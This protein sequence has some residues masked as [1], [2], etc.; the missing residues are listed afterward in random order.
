MWPFNRKKKVSGVPKNQNP[1][2]VPSRRTNYGG[3]LGTVSSP[4]IHSEAR[5]DDAT[6]NLIT[7]M[8]IG[9]A[10]SNNDD[11]SHHSHHSNS[12][13]SDSGSWGGGHS[14]G[15]GSSSSY[16]S[17]SYDSGSSSS[18]SGSYSSSD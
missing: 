15:G 7:G 4:R 8:I 12:H 2:P 16:D 5:R 10:M 9:S 17:G 3:Y 14:D 1:P 18:D 6:D 13:D 11:H